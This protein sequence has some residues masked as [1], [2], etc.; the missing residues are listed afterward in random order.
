[1]LRYRVALEMPVTRQI[2][3]VVTQVFGRAIASI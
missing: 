2:S 1:V 3:F